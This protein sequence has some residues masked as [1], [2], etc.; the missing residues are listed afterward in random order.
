M[1]KQEW[2]NEERPG[3]QRKAMT[4]AGMDSWRKVENLNKGEECKEKYYEPWQVMGGGSR[5][6]RKKKTGKEKVYEKG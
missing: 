3:K 4:S 2:G 1:W 6:K 5:E